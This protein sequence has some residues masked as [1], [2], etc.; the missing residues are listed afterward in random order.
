MI[1]KEH[2]QNTQTGC[3]F[4]DACIR[5]LAYKENYYSKNRNDVKPWPITGAGAPTSPTPGQPGYPV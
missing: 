3:T 2:E 5:S 1:K 4:N